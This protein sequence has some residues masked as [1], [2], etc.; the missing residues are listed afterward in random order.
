MVILAARIARA[1][2]ASR[3]SHSRAAAQCTRLRLRVERPYLGLASPVR[4]RQ[5]D[6]FTVFIRPRRGRAVTFAN[7]SPTC[8][9]SKPAPRTPFPPPISKHPETRDKYS[10][11][12]AASLRSG[13]PASSVIVPC[14]FCYVLCRSARSVSEKIGRPIRPRPGSYFLVKR[15]STSILLLIMTYNILRHSMIDTRRVHIREVWS[16]R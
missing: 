4:P 9:R 12:F 13:S 1:P 3:P 14:R 8:T 11:S 2:K 6:F 10:P 16:R 7:S 15:A 5:P